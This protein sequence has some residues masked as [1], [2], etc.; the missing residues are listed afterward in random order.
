M[1]R[2]ARKNK[3]KNKITYYENIRFSSKKEA[4]RYIELKLLE[5]TNQIKELEL[6]KKF[7]LQPSY[8][9]NGKTIRSIN[10]YADFYYY[11]IIKGKYIVEDTKGMKTEVYKLK[12]KIF[13]YKYDITIIET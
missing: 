1:K 2:Y 4:Q 7:E 3:Y 9:K 8:K 11:D 5:K 6:Q 10:Y 13:E 12:K